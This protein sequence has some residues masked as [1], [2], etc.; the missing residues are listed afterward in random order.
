MINKERIEPIPDPRL[1]TPLYYQLQTILNAKIDNGDWQPGDLIPTENELIKM[2]N[3][4]RTTVREAINALVNEGK[5]E[6]RQGRGTTVCKPKIV[7]TL[8]HL[9]G[10]SEE[11][12]NKGYEPG[13]KLLLEER[14]VAPDKVA[15]KLNLAKGAEVYHIKRVR[16]ANNE[17]IAIEQT[18]WPLE[19][20][21]YFAGEDLSTA[22]FYSLIENNGVQLKDAEEFISAS[23]ASKEHAQHLD[24]KE[25]TPLLKLERITYSLRGVPVE[26]CFNEFRSDRY[27][28]RV[29]LQ[30]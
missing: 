5:L 28:Y 26:Y 12:I 2:Y 20:A 6:K 14:I 25:N 23:A 29:H 9:T 22:A 30:R 15:E 4:S 19:I 3:V 18:Y 10:F 8:G 13:A 16:L 11:M 27:N 24:I 1:P 21:Q 17:P 7:E